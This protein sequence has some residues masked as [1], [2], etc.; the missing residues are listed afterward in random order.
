MQNGSITMVSVEQCNW[1]FQPHNCDCSIN[2]AILLPSTDLMPHETW[3]KAKP[4]H[5]NDATVFFKFD[6]SSI[7][8]AAVKF[9]RQVFMGIGIK[10]E[11]TGGLTSTSANGKCI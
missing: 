6:S 4:L 9:S 1:D 7:V 10:S 5:C 8:R 11:T 3:L 2:T